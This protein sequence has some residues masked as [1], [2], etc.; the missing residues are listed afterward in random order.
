[1]A[2]ECQGKFWAGKIT[3]AVEDLEKVVSRIEV[4][5]KNHLEH[6]MEVEQKRQDRLF[7]VIV[8]I[9]GAL[10]IILQTYM[11]IKMT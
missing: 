1:M 6:H 3:K 5:L 7:K 2:E 11:I 8:S 10:L 4:A 9:G